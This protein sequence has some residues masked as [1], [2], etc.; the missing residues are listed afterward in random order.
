MCPIQQNFRCAQNFFDTYVDI[1]L[2][3]YSS[4]ELMENLFVNFSCK[5]NSKKIFFC[6]NCHD[7]AQFFLMSDVV[8]HKKTLM[9]LRDLE[10][11][12]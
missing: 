9:T 11:L 7:K 5:K 6:L 1:L 2:K 3:V 8:L 4:L 10:Q 12:C